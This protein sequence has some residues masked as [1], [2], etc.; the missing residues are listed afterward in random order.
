MFFAPEK[1]LCVFEGFS[2][3][4]W[5]ARDPDLLDYRVGVLFEFSDVK[6]PVE[7]TY[8]VNKYG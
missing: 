5:V 2:E 7:Y 3:F 8:E 4:S 6:E 1:A